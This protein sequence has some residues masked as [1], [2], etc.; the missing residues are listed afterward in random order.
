MFLEDT[1]VREP[2]YMAI[3]SGEFVI[4]R[5]IKRRIIPVYGLRQIAY[6]SP[7]LSYPKAVTVKA[8]GELRP[9]NEFVLLDSLYSIEEFKKCIPRY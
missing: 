9:N 3:N 1:F 8:Y 2:H 7:R 5:L 4:G 6:T